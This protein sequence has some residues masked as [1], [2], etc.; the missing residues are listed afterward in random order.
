MDSIKPYRAVEAKNG[1]IQLCHLNLKVRVISDSSAVD[2]EL[3]S[4]LMNN[5]RTDVE[6]IRASFAICC[7]NEGGVQ[8]K[9]DQNIVEWSTIPIPR[10]SSRGVEFDGVQQSLLCLLLM[11]RK[12]RMEHF[13]QC[14]IRVEEPRDSSILRLHGSE[15]QK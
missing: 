4:T 10:S 3:T 9:S 1:S 2:D 13:G 8:R 5:V 12:L 14:W 11:Q 6:L 7:V 15:E